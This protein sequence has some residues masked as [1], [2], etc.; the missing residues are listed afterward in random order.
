MLVEPDQPPRLLGLAPG[1]AADQ[2]EALAQRRQRLARRRRHRRV[3]GPLDDRR[4][5]AVDVGED[6]RPARVGAQRLQQRGPGAVPRLRFAR[7]GI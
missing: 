5:G 3:L 2:A 1:D 6:R 4:Q 7:H